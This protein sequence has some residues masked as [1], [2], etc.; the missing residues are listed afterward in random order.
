MSSNLARKVILSLR[1]FVAHYRKAPLQ[2]GAIIIGIILAVTLLTG[3]RAINENAKRSY[4]ETTELLSQQ[5]DWFVT[6]A[7]GQKHLTETVYFELRKAGISHSLPVVEGR[8]RSSDGKRWQIQ[9]SDIITAITAPGQDNN[10]EV[11]RISLLD[12][13]I[14]L[15]RMLAGEPVVLMSQ[16]KADELEARQPFVLGGQEVEIITLEDSFNLG[17]RILMDISLAQTL[18]RVEGQLSYIAL[19]DINSAQTQ[20]IIELIGQDANLNQADKGDSLNALTDSFHLNLTAMSMLAFV[21]GLFI[22]YNGIRY[23]LLKRQRLFTQLQQLGTEKRS[24]ILALALELLLLVLIGSTIGFVLGLQLSHWFH[25]LVSV[26]LEQ[27]YGATILPGAWNWSWL[28][29]AIALTLGAALIASSALIMQLYKQPL[30]RHSGQ[31]NQQTHSSVVY[32]IQIK[33]SL[34]LVLIVVISLPLTKDHRVTMLLLGLLVVAIP[35]ALPWLLKSLTHLITELATKMKARGL[36]Y[37]QIAETKE[38]V[39][40]LSLAMMAMLLAV[41]ANI[42]MNTLV[43]SFESTLTNWLSARLHADLYVRPAESQMQQTEQFLLKQPQVE[44]VYKQYFLESSYEGFPIYLVTKDKSTLE[45]TTIFKSKEPDI[46]QRFYQ[47]EL[48]ILSEPMAVRLGIEQ[49]EAIT[50]EAIPDRTFTVG[51]VFYDYGNPY[52]EVLIAPSIWRALDFSTMPTSLGASIAGGQE[53]LRQALIDDLRIPETLLFDQKQIRQYAIDIFNKTFAI[54]KVLNSLT[55]LVAAIGLFSACFMLTQARVAPIARLYSL[56]VSQ[57][58]L[59]MMV[60]SQMLIIVLLTCLIALPT[61]AVLGYVLINKVTLQAFGWSI[62]MIWN[63]QAYLEVVML[64]ITASVIA[65]ALPL[66]RL[67]RR[68]L[69][70][71]LQSEVI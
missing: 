67:T 1:V 46:W 17:N 22:A 69:V 56:G 13:N 4:S 71:S 61:G 11:E 30:S 14:P 60:V 38:L 45:Q 54:T 8:L 2:A 25:P 57:K 39:A 3:V 16:S 42:S 35:L 5:A 9:G 66:Y 70:S 23:S 62:H 55:L 34:L 50:L 31:Y 15:N 32:R 7:T 40:P 48:V 49:R 24:L 36:T 33:I 44:K 65:V 19:F 20:Q 53:A 10:K 26:T 27:L 41:T 47:G 43:G 6:P 64:A 37:Y 68:P 18:L 28:F 58:K 29:Q 12:T 52:G 63:W 59:S 51:G 21:V